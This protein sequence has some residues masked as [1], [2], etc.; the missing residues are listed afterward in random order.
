MER[1]ENSPIIEAAAWIESLEHE[2]QE[3]VNARDYLQRGNIQF[4]RVDV[5]FQGGFH[6]PAAQAL[7]LAEEAINR[8]KGQIDEQKNKL[9]A[10]TNGTN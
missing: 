9:N 5:I 1:T 6:I 10:L 3:A 4:T 8:I 2:L 7:S